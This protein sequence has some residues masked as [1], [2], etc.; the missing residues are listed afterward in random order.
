MPRNS[1]G[2]YS[3]PAGQPVVTNTTIGSSVF[4][5][6]TADLASEM[7]DSLD[8]SGKGAMLAQFVAVD[9][10][11]TAPGVSFSNDHSTG[12]YGDAGDVVVTS[13]GDLAR[14]S[15]SG[16]T[17]AGPLIVTAQTQTTHA[18]AY[19]SNWS[20]STT[21]TYWKDT[22]TGLVHIQ[23]IAVAGAGAGAT[24]L[25]L[26]AGFRPSATRL[27]ICYA[28]TMGIDTSG[29]GYAIPVSVASTGAVSVGRTI[30]A[31]NGAVGQLPS[32][33][34]TGGHYALDG[35]CFLGA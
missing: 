4:N 32:V 35:I 23:G 5:A 27:F 24:I 28:D 18:A 30:V 7:T 17:L 21:V 22:V 3:L 16:V 12:I 2:A 19:S 34:H 11:E 9:G 25:T 13:G 15:H 31:V 8:R 20:D 1:G 33:P 26:P 10:N 14:F 6:L 29:T